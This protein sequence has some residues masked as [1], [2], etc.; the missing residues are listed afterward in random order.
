M[1]L[2]S[3][4]ASFILMMLTFMEFIPQL[5][6]ALGGEEIPQASNLLAPPWMAQRLR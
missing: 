1:P 4:D 5:L 6:E 3:F 2:A